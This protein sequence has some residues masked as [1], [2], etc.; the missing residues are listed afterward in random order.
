[1]TTISLKIPTTLEQRLAD[2]ARKRGTSRS[3]VVRSALERLVDDEDV[4]PGSCLAL[5]SDLVGSVDGPLDLSHNKKRL[6]G[7]GK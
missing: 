5:M 3:E 2:L 1:M 7:F 4:R 6:E